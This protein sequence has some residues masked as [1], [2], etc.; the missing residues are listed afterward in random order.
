MDLPKA[1]DCLPHDLL[2]TK[3]KAYGQSH[4]ATDLVHS[5]LNNRKQ[6]VSMGQNLSTFETIVKG[7]PQGSILGPLLFN[8]FIND[9]LYLF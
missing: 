2:L 4:S 6:C 1:F 8:I 9:I 5:Y 3:L 7:V